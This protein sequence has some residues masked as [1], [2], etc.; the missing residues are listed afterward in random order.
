VDDNLVT[1]REPED[2]PAFNRELIR[3]Y[4][5]YRRRYAAA[6]EQVARAGS[7]ER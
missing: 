2:I 4:R 1:R 6:R 5:I 7:G 3:T